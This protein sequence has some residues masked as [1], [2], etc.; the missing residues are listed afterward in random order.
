MFGT[1]INTCEC[2][3]GISSQRCIKLGI[4]RRKAASLGQSICQC[5]DTALDGIAPFTTDETGRIKSGIDEGMKPGGGSTP[6]SISIARCRRAFLSQSSAL[7]LKNQYV[8]FYFCIF[9][10]KR[11]EIFTWKSLAGV[12]IVRSLKL[13]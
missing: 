8:P 6:S 9:V 7:Y 11:L 12:A 5:V 10:T 13:V 3:R 1:S 2:M 4:I